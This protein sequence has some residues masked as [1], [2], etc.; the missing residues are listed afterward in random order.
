MAANPQSSIPNIESLDPN[1]W[2]KES[3][4][5]SSTFVYKGVKE[6]EKVPQE[7]IDAAIP[8][9]ERRIATGGYRL[10]NML[11]AMDLTTAWAKSELIAAPISEA[12]SEIAPID[13]II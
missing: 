13:D 5:I 11:K 3:F 4:D 6:N 2:S 9:A 8:V 10:A 12:L 7:Y 1:V